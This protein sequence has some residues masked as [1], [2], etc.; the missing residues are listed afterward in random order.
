MQFYQNPEELRLRIA[1]Y[2]SGNLSAE[3]SVRLLA[4]VSSDEEGSKL[5]WEMSL[6]W[7][8]SCSEAFASDEEKNLALIKSRI[9]PAQSS[10]LRW[11]NA[12]WLAAAAAAALLLTIGSNIL[13][14][15]SN[16][17]IKETYT[18]VTEPYRITVPESC[19]TEVTLPDGSTVMLNSGSE[20]TYGHDFA[21]F[22]R[23][24]TL[25]GEGYFNVSKDEQMPFCVTSH[26]MELKVKGTTFNMTAYDDE[27]YIVVSLL[28]GR[29]D[30]LSGNGTSIELFPNEQ[31]RYSKRSGA[32]VKKIA[33]VKAA[34]DWLDGG[35]SFENMPFPY[36]AHR[37]EHKFN[38]TIIINS[39]KLRGEYYTGSFTAEQSLQDILTEIDVEGQY[40]WK[41]GN[42]TLT[43]SDRKK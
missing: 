35:L 28:E 27:D 29:V 19:R 25:T 2:L 30:I 31:A 42:G 38:V 34:A 32:L 10:R 20:L 23:R 12:K 1:E 3:D 22:E 7:S 37:L 14:Y 26:N 11:L 17:R 9:K 13:W 41:S 4:S 6:L 33:N 43:I 5:F 16:G 18:Q 24:V 39:S 36:I 8:V 21:I 15:R 40:E